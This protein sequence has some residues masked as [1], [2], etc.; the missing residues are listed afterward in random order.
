MIQAI[1]HLCLDKDGTLIDVHQSWV[2]I[3]QRRTFKT[4]QFYGL[5]EDFHEPLALAMGVDLKSQR[6]IPGGP[7]G[8]QPRPVIIEQTV[9]WLKGR[10]VPATVEELTDIFKSVDRDVQAASDFNARPLPGVVDGIRRLKQTGLKISVYTSD[11]HKNTELVLAQ[12]GL[13]QYVDA[14]V[15]GDDV[16]RP[17]PDPE[18]FVKA[19]QAVGVPAENSMY[20]GDTLDDMRMVKGHGYGVAQGLVSRNELAGAAQQAFETFTDLTEHVLQ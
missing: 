7:V 2:P 15:G 3:T 5:N 6:I 18:G 9:Q 16:T 12:L 1:K 4:R 10:K 20:V 11:R 19:C 8:Y 14:I 13:D 17:K